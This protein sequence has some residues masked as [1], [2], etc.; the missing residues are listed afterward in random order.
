MQHVHTG[1]GRRADEA[2]R[3]FGLSAIYVYVCI[4]YVYTYIYTSGLIYLPTYL[5][6][7]I[8]LCLWFASMFQVE[9]S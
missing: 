9:A 3:Y 5:H 2:K 8:A 7:C 1:K 6:K 4:G